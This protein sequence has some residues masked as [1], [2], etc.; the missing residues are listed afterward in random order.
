M[1]ARTAP[2]RTGF[3]PR[4]LPLA[5][6][7]IGSFMSLLDSTIVNIALPTIL[8]D[9]GASLESGQLV[10]TVYL[11]ALAVVIPVSGYLGERFGM[12]RLYIVTLILFTAGSTL[13]GFA[14]NLPSLIVFRVLQ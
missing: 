1:T 5:V 4:W 7:T 14:W 6:T 3:D 10:L 9:F 11:V 13:C 8:R 2:A 12:K